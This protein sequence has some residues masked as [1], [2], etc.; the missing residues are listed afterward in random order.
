MEQAQFQEFVWMQG[1]LLH[2]A[3]MVHL[4]F[5]EAEVNLFEESRP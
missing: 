4:A 2:D 5:V 1:D 3:V